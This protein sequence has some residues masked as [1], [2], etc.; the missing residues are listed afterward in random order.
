M[1]LKSEM[2]VRERSLLWTLLVGWMAG[3]DFFFLY[4]FGV[5]VLFKPLPGGGLLNLS[6]CS[7]ST[8]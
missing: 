1:R 5:C 6:Y 4:C 8:I 7:K 2:V 3:V